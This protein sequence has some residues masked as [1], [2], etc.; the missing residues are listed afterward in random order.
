MAAG[1][2]LCQ[3]ATVLRDVFWQKVYEGQGGDEGQRP[4]SP[5]RRPYNPIEK[6]SK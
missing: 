5:S 2:I 1:T 6:K 3:N 4:L